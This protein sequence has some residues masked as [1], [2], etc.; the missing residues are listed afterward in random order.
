MKNIFNSLWIMFG[1]GDAAP[2]CPWKFDVAKPQLYLLA[3]PGDSAKYARLEGSAAA[4]AMR[5]NGILHLGDVRVL[6]VSLKISRLR[7]NLP[8]A[9][10]S[11]DE[12][13]I[14]RFRFQQEV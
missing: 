2:P 7:K 1:L 6:D 5:D 11:L 14:E 12:G 10:L 8:E 9:K 13:S 3:D 4:P